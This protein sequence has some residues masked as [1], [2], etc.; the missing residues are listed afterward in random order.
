MTDLSRFAALNN[1]TQELAASP[2]F[3]EALNQTLKL[4]ATLVSADYSLLVLFNKNARGW[5]LHSSYGVALEAVGDRGNAALQAVKSGAPVADGPAV[6]L[7]LKARGLMVGALQVSR[8]SGLTPADRLVFE[9]FAAAAAIAID[10]TLS[11]TEFVSTVTHELRLPMTS[12]K[13]YSDLIRGGMAGPVS[14][15]QKQLLDTV[16]NNVDWMNALISDLSDIAKI[17]T[18]RLKAESEIV[19]PA[20]VITEAVSA[21]RPQ[22]EAKA[23]ILTVNVGELPA[24]RADRK[25]LAQMLTYLLTNA[26]R[27]TAEKGQITVSAELQGPSVRFT[28]AD[29]GVGM[30]P[31]D[32]AKLFTQFFRSED[33]VVRDHK[34]WGLALHLVKKLAELFGGEVGA[35]SEYGQGSAFWF[36]LPTA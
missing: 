4:A 22:F 2:G 21:L 16:R 15:M 32:K 14:D 17:E 6:A 30:T 26:N 31:E 12:I 1:A 7:P 34:G 19:E 5:V 10:S 27:Y 11:K 28:V 35:D 25:R 3:A 24:V 9:I 29:T 23:Q 18:G 36:T 8:E 13:G 33:P 20:A